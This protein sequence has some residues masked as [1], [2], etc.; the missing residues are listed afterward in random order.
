MKKYLKMVTGSFVFLLALISFAGT[1]SAYVVITG[2]SVTY[3]PG[4]NECSVTTYYT[5]TNSDGTTSTG[6]TTTAG[7]LKMTQGGLISCNIGGARKND[8]GD[9]DVNINFDSKGQPIF[10]SD[11][12]PVLGNRNNNDVGVAQIVLKNEGLISN[13]DWNFGPTT[14]AGLINFQKKYN[15]AP[16]GM[17]DKATKDLMTQKLLNLNTQGTTP[18]PAQS[19][20]ASV[21]PVSIKETTTA[22]EKIKQQ[23]ADLTNALS[24]LGQQ[25]SVISTSLL[26]GQ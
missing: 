12:A 14:K 1:A 13:I 5:V 22:L 24:S 8:V 19:T 2:T 18:I 10:F 3:G 23:I 6:S 25:A 4:A 11:K 26:K 17:F 16:T 21:A 20:P 15:L 7:T 9:K